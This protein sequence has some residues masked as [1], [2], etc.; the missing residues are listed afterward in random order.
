V[1]ANDVE[2]TDVKAKMWFVFT[3]GP[4]GVPAFVLSPH[5]GTAARAQGV[6]K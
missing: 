2:A 4:A 5:G 6:Q 1:D 3:D